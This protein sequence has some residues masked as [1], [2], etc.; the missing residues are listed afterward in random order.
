MFYSRQIYSGLKAELK[1]KEAIV[2]T[3]MRQ[4]GKT[5]LLREL[6]SS[7]S[8]PNKVFLDFENPLHTQI[9]EKENFDNIWADLADFGIVKEKRAYIFIDEA[10]NLPMISRVIKYLVD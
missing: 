6:Y 10:Q 4:V 7:I 9:F 1:T 8:S 3:G 2:L 5:T